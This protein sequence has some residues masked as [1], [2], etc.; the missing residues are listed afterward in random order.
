MEYKIAMIDDDT[1]QLTY[2]TKL[3][4]EWSRD[5][6]FLVSLKSYSGAEPFLFD[7]E[8]EKDFDMLLLDIEMGEMDGVTLAKELR[9]DDDR[10]QIIFV[11]GYSDY[12]AQG[13]EVS[14]LHYLL[15]PVGREKLFSVLD[16]AA[17]RLHRDERTLDIRSAGALLRIPFRQ[18]R[19][20]EAQRNYCII[21]ANTAVSV[22]MPLGELME[23]L[24]ERFY[25]AGR[26][27][28]VNLNCISRVTKTK[29]I[30]Q[31][32]TE[33]LLPRGAY[34]GINRAIIAWDDGSRG[35]GKG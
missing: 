11:T 6:G 10:M 14:A 34:D 13:Y 5:S 17:K 22:K 3:V 8:E 25:R 35:C 28:I 1:E 31:D 30:L 18:I 29:I 20:A 16:R 7:Y 27:V 15:K 4:R 23:K 33:I 21:H 19:Y 2:L 32:G 24:D 9:R 12:I 26:S